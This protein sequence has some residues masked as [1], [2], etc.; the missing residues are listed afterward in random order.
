MIKAVSS[1]KS[2]LKCIKAFYYLSSVA[3]FL[4][5]HTYNITY[6]CI[7]DINVQYLNYLVNKSVSVYKGIMYSISLIL[8][9]FSRYCIKINLYLYVNFIKFRHPIVDLK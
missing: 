8:L 4:C 2:H 7:I 9:G 5:N 6:K 3:H 1:S